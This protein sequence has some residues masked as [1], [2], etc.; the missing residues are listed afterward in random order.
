MF[1]KSRFLRKFFG[2]ILLQN[3][4][5]LTTKNAH[6]HTQAKNAFCKHTFIYLSRVVPVEK[7]WSC[8]EVCPHDTH[9]HEENMWKMWRNNVYNLWYFVTFY[10][11][12]SQNL[13]CCDLS[14]FVWRKIV[15]MIVPVKT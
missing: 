1:Y 11:V 9:T 4:I 6:I 8:R 15:P 3:R 12:L 13:F 14:A 2:S 10:A 7:I 5:F